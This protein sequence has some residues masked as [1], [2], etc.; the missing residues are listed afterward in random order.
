[1]SRTRRGDLATFLVRVDDKG[2]LDMVDQRRGR[3]VFCFPRSAD[4]IAF[5]PRRMPV[6]AA[7]ET[8]A[9]LWYQPN[10][11]SLAAWQTALQ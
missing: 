7:L 5:V 1:M 3:D 4:R 8:A 2:V 6:A 9:M 10:R 11:R